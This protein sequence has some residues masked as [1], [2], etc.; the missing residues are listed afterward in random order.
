MYHPYPQYRDLIVAKG[1]FPLGQKENP[2]PCSDMAGEILAV[3]D[4]VKGWTPGDRVC[5]NFA[6]DHVFGDVT[7]EIKATG[8]GA[9]IDGVLTEYKILPAHVSYSAV[10]RIWH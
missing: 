3:G 10:P 5:S 4:D 7:A 2:V 6:L 9:P 1:T 8:L